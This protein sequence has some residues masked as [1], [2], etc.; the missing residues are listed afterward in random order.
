[1]YKKDLFRFAEGTKT[2]QE[3]RYPTIEREHRVGYEGG[4]PGRV[5]PEMGRQVKGVGR[6]EVGDGRHENI[7][8][9]RGKC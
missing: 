8:K 7:G 6:Q 1:M 9:G 4:T 2:R 5:K 3:R